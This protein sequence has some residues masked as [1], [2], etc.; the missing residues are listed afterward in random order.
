MAYVVLSH[1]FVI[2][3]LYVGDNSPWFLRL[4]QRPFSCV[5]AG[6]EFDTCET[7]PFPD[8]IS[9]ATNCATAFY[10]RDVCTV[11]NIR[12]SYIYQNSSVKYDKF[13]DISIRIKICQ[14]RRWLP[15]PWANVH[16]LV[17]C[18]LEC[19]W[20]ATG[21]PSVHWDTTGWPSEYLQ[22]TLEHHWKNLVETAP[23][24]NATGET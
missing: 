16:W 22:G 15:L 14:K 20:N 6:P 17:Q 21:W 3:I 23:H 18:T 9:L 13:I 11:M 8:C 4:K 2:I 1:W 5:F 7:G 12:M 10:V 24:W 19:H